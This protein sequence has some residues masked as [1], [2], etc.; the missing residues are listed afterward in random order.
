MQVIAPKEASV[1][2]RD[3]KLP[4]RCLPVTSDT[5]PYTYP[6]YGHLKVRERSQWLRM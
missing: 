4:C 3:P 2:N 5:R 1:G 6:K